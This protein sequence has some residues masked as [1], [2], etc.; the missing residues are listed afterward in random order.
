LFARAAARF[1]LRARRPGPGVARAQNRALRRAALSPRALSLVALTLFTLLKTSVGSAQSWSDAREDPALF[2]IVTIDA[3]GESGF[4]YGREDVAG[5]GLDMFSAAEAG[6]DL[7]TVY[8][9]TDPMRLWLRAYL[10]ASAAPGASLRAFFFIDA[11]ARN[12]TGGPAQGAPLDKALTKDPSSGGYELAVA[13]RGNGMVLGVFAWNAG[14]RAWLEDKDAAAPDVE[15]EQGVSLDPLAIG[16]TRHGYVQL[17]LAHSVSGLSQSCAGTFFV[18]LLD[19]GPAMRSF[20]DDAPEEFACHAP[21]DAYGV[22]IVLQPDGCN[23]DTECPGAGSCRDGVC[24][25]AYPCAGNEDCPSDYSCMQDRCVRVVSGSCNEEADCDGLVCVDARCV[26]CTENGARAC[27]SGLTCAPDGSCVDTHDVGGSGG[28]GTQGPG[29]VRGGAFS[30]AISTTQASLGSLL[31]LALG[32]IVLRRRR[33]RRALNS[34]DAKRAG[35]RAS[36]TRRPL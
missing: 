22:P 36:E 30:C 10:A 11:D 20:A 3:T 29:K 33:R 15:A 21:E 9:S 14:M 1:A 31:P 5:D 17:A 24:L 34:A 35:W 26:A 12:D 2:Q 25:V 28:N 27:R 19:Q 6:A 4:P 16:A 13:V 7:R 32:L 23:S 18:R 8:A